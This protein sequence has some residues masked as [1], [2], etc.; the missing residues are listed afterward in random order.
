MNSINKII[1]IGTNHHNTLSMVRCFGEEGRKVSL[2]IYG[3]D[4]SYI[5]LS[6]Y[7][8]E[9]YY[10]KTAEDAI[11]QLVMKVDSLIKPLIIVCSDEASS[12]IDQFY[13]QLNKNYHF[14]N[15]GCAGR[16][17]HYM[18]KQLQMKVAADCGFESLG[19]RN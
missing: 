18:N 9:V 5:A 17:T 6:K 2:Y 10:F 13:D 4:N 16:I 11:H 1:I 8:E 3:D 7:V 14:F 15:A 19:G 12:M